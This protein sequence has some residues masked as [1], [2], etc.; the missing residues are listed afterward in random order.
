MS[1]DESISTSPPIMS[2]PHDDIPSPIVLS[3]HEYESPFETHAHEIVFEKLN[4]PPTVDIGIQASIP[5]FDIGVNTDLKA[6]EFW[7]HVN[8]TQK[9]VAK[10]ERY[11]QVLGELNKEKSERMVNE[12]LVKILQSDVTDLQQRNVAEAT[13]RLRLE[14]EIAD[15]EVYMNR[16]Q[17]NHFCFYVG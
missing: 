13:T 6:Y 1:Y 8:E 3:Q 16:I 14:S 11:Q 15:L 2:H 5:L 12:H 9:S 17:S 7:E 4:A 10:E